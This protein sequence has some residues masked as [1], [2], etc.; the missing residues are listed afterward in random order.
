MKYKPN[1]VKHLHKLASKV[2]HIDYDT[3]NL[4]INGYL[5]L[6][7]LNHLSMFTGLDA[8]KTK[9]VK[10]KVFEGYITPSPSVLFDMPYNT[11]AFSGTDYAT[12][13]TDLDLSLKEISNRRPS[14]NIGRIMDAKYILEHFFG[15]IPAFLLTRQRHVPILIFEYI[16]ETNEI[17]FS[18]FLHVEKKLFYKCKMDNIK[19]NNS[20][21]SIHSQYY[22]KHCWEEL[23][24][25]KTKEM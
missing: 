16:T 12:Y 19:M 3:L 24:K 13:T 14:G 7:E 6:T 17:I 21:F 15:F 1:Y 5:G 25:L 22:V 11:E 4:Y 9:T 20:L 10:T 23:Q 18:N 2:G 8:I